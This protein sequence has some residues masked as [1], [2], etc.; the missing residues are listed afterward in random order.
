MRLIP[1]P[2]QTQARPPNR[3]PASLLGSGQATTYGKREET[4]RAP[5]H[6]NVDAD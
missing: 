4:R 3:S 6:R 5:I 1:A 2:A